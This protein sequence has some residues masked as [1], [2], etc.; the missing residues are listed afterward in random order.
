[1][2]I[3]EA[4]LKT[5]GKGQSLTPE[6]MWEAVQPYHGK[7]KKVKVTES[8]WQDATWP[9]AKSAMSL[10]QLIGSTEHPITEETYKKAAAMQFSSPA[11]EKDEDGALTDAG[12]LKI[13]EAF[14]KTIGK[15][16]K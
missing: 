8:V 5:V 11:F 10:A 15:G 4:F 13:C 1:M 7:G 6:K 14:L 9:L 12:G 2:G 16:R 3:C